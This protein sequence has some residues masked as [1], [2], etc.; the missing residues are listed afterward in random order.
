MSSYEPYLHHYAPGSHSTH[1]L[2]YGDCYYSDHSRTSSPHTLPPGGLPSYA[3]PP[4]GSRSRRP[5]SPQRDPGP[6]LD[7]S[8]EYQF[9]QR[10]RIVEYRTPSRYPVFGD[11]LAQPGERRDGRGVALPQWFWDAGLGEGRR[12]AGSTANR[13][14]EDMARETEES[15]RRG[16]ERFDQARCRSTSSR[17]HES[18]G[19]YTKGYS[20]GVDHGY[21]LQYQ[22][23]GEDEES[24]PWYV[25]ET[26][27]ETD[28]C[29]G[30]MSCLRLGEM[31]RGDRGRCQNVRFQME[32]D[33]RS[34]SSSER[35][36]NGE[37]WQTTASRKYTK[38]GALR[39][40]V[41]RN[42]RSRDKKGE[43]FRLKNGQKAWVQPKKSKGKKVR[44][45][46][47]LG[48]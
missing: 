13:V 43:Y 12:R 40:F 38:V 27:T 34:E 11:H 33:T 44:R 19:R 4:R 17:A 2:Y 36:S 35:T 45:Y 48:A 29:V 14:H 23:Y 46:K 18:Y 10:R 25:S 41:E 22:H 6:R 15:R 8:R 37:E 42:V 20:E 5:A 39:R 30:P 1:H 26:D 16:G 31:I 21:G 7:D 3:G 32:D 28:T 9:R 24:H 47:G